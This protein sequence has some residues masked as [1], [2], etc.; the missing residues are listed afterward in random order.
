MLAFLAGKP[1]NLHNSQYWISSRKEFGINIYRV[2]ALRTF[3]ETCTN[4]N[5]R[6]ILLLGTNSHSDGGM[7]SSKLSKCASEK[8]KISVV[9]SQFDMQIVGDAKI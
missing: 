6:P 1:A 7:A 3:C 8:K 5:F 9:K 2:A 4:V